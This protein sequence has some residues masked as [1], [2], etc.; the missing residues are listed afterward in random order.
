M[1][2][3]QWTMAAIR[4]TGGFFTKLPANRCRA[5]AA[6]RPEMN[7]FISI[8]PVPGKKLVLSSNL[9]SDPAKGTVSNT[10]NQIYKNLNDPIWDGFFTTMK[11]PLPVKQTARAGIQKAFLCFN[12]R[13]NSAFWMI[14]SAPKFALKGAYGYPKTAT[15]NA[16]TFLCITLKDADTAKDIAAQMFVAQQP[17]V[18]LA[19]KVPASMSSDDPRAK[20]INNTVLSERTSYANFITF[21]SKSRANRSN[22][23]RVTNF[24]IKSAM[25]IFITTS[26]GLRSRRVSKLKHGSTIPFPAIWMTTK[27]IPSPR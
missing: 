16:Q 3:R 20:L 14:H 1:L 26:S 12:L 4:L 18:Y 11:I 27:C 17:N 13:T 9:I 7:M 19:S 5:T 8:L 6:K 24:G 2:Y 15:G 21:L 23:S 25:T 22:V 10:L